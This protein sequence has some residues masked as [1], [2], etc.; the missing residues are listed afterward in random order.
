MNCSR[1]SLPVKLRPQGA[2]RPPGV[3]RL[4]GT[5]FLALAILLIP[6]A[7]L[8]LTL[9]ASGIDPGEMLRAWTAGE[10]ASKEYRI[11]MY[12]RLPRT[13][14]AMLAGAAL[15]VS[16]WILQTILVNPLASPGII[17]VNAGAGLFALI[18]MIA[19]PGLSLAVPMGAFWG[20]LVAALVIYFVARKTGASRTTIVL[21]GVAISGIL[22]A[23]MDAL[24]TVWPDAALSRAFF[25]IG[26]FSDVTMRKLA[27]A[28]PLIS[29]GFVMA[30][31]LRRE[32]S[33]L[34]LGDDMAAGLG[35]N[36]QRNRFLLILA[37][38]LMAGGAVSFAGLLGFVGL[39]VPHIAR[40]LTRRDERWG[41]PMCMVLGA[42]FLV[43]CD[44]TARLLF[45]PYE[46]PVG[47]ILS[48]MGGPF[49]LYILYTQKRSNRHD[50][51]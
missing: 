21:S 28:L 13:A 19:L 22:S 5:I 51:A 46:L 16:G 7:L 47:V 12:V 15:A 41:V 40:M 11:F 42:L 14:A 6:A 23:G 2:L 45:S 8:S 36:I 27:M 4:P 49:F 1:I 31:L 18:A 30:L 44:L 25:S 48:L 10:I 50:A 32:A 43:L 9:G 34:S 37:S 29:I 38:A 17:G 35:L 39:V 24:V 26:G 20:A 33:I 3:L